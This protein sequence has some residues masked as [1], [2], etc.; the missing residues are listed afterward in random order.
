MSSGRHLVANRNWWNY[1]F[2]NTI[3][4]AYKTHATLPLP[5]IQPVL[6]ERRNEIE[7]NQLVVYVLNFH[8]QELQEPF[9]AII[10]GIKKPIFL[11]SRQIFY[12]RWRFA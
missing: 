9:G 2:A 11:P 7:G 8:G 6:D 4:Y 1:D 5:G 12:W 3:C 10:K